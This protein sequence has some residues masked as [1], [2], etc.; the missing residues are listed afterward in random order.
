VDPVTVDRSPNPALRLFDRIEVRFLDD[1]DATKFSPESG[2]SFSI[3]P[4]I[5]RATGEY[6]HESREDVEQGDESG[7]EKFLFGQQTTR[8][9]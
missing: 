7:D 8:L 9:S 2:A 6:R 5:P 4:Q 1:H 3:H